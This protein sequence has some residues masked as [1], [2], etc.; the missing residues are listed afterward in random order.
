LE[1]VEKN[2]KR[3]LEHAEYIVNISKWNKQFKKPLSLKDFERFTGF[4]TGI[5]SITTKNFIK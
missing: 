2:K 1:I 4:K 5:K 3:Y